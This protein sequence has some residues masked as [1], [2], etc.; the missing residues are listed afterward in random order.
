M[1]TKNCTLNN[2]EGVP[3]FATWAKGKRLVCTLMGR[4][5]PKSYRR[6]RSLFETLYLSYC[7]RLAKMVGVTGIEPVTPTMST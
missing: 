7:I 6:R 4:N 3:L 5:L 1:S 2:I